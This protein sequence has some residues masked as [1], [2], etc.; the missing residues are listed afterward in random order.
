MPTIT[1]A[2]SCLTLA[3]TFSA[4]STLDARSARP[5]AAITAQLER[6]TVSVGEAVTLSG[7]VR[8][9]VKTLVNIQRRQGGS[10][11]AL[12]STL[13]AITGTYSLKFAAGRAGTYSLRAMLSGRASRAVAISPTRTL[14]VAT[15]PLPTPATKPSQQSASDGQPTAF[16]A[17][18]A[19][20]ADQ[21]PTADKVPAISADIAIVNDWFA[22]QTGRTLQPRWTRDTAGAVAVTTITLPRT[23]ARYRGASFDS[24]VADI[25]AVSPTPTSQRTV[26]WVDVNSNEGCGVTGERTSVLFEAACDIHP[27][28]DDS[29]PYGATYLLAHEMTHAFGAVD[30]CA[31]HHDSGGHISDD[32]R[33][34]LY[35]GAKE[36]DWAHLMLDPGHDDY[37]QTGRSNC[38]GIETSPYWMAVAP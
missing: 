38:P 9:A 18:Y 6:S 3:L 36:R 27:A 4:A 35:I 12:G 24:V 26:V 34:I 22:T 25:E 10:W 13:S 30:P 1:R 14:T 21:V 28:A 29:W 11:V 7:T 2:A 23:A 17:V 8:P 16:R 20:A 32:P 15:A 31:P 19:L 5:R 37:F 33:D